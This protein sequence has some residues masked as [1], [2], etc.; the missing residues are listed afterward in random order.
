MMAADLGALSLLLALALGAYAGIGSVL[1]AWR[2]STEL[3][4]SARY[5]LY[6]LPVPL[7]VATLT[8]VA[9]FANHDF[10]L[11]Y[12]A[13]HSNLAM[14]PI[15]TWV[16]F[17]AGNEGSLLYIALAFSV[18]A[19]IAVGTAPRP[20]RSALPYTSAIL[21]AVMVFFLAVMATMAN[22]FA[23]LDAVPPDGRGI[24]P[25]L[26]HAGMFFHPPMLML[27]LIGV[28][29][30][31]A[32]A[33]GHLVSGPAED[34]WVD[35]GRRWGL[36]VWTVLTIGLLLGSWWAY[37]ILGWGGY[38]AWD[39]V[40][41]AGLLPWLPL[42][43]FVHSIMVQKRRGMFRLWNVAL[44][45][46]AFGMALYGMFMNRGGPVPSVHS[47]GQSTMGWVFLAF[48][49]AVVVGSFMAFF[50]RYNAFRSAAPLDSALSREAA[51]LVNNLLFLAIAFVVLWGVVFPLLS[52]AFKGETVTVARP[53]YD[54]VT[55]PLFLALLL[56]MGIA[57]LV[58]WRRASAKRLREALLWPVIV[59]IAVAA[60]AVIL[61]VR[62]PLPVVAFAF[63][64]AAATGILREW[65]KGTMA[66]HRRGHAYPSA[67]WSLLTANRPRYGGYV[68]HLGIV[69]LAVSVA[70]SSFYS[71]QR[72]VSLK[73]GGSATLG[74]YTLVYDGASVVQKADRTD[75]TASVRV[76]R[77]GRFLRTLEPG[78]SYYPEFNT[79]AAHAGIRSTP[80]E[81]LYIIANEF[82]GDGSAVFRLHVNPLVMWMWVSGGLFLA[83]MVVSLWPEAATVRAPS[84]VSS[85]VPAAASKRT[86]EVS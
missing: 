62:K 20:A 37:T 63:S 13:K 21:M 18:I 34:E 45:N 25:L 80:A 52:D 85:Q 22:P 66:Q 61:G 33:M 6:V 2:R 72:D 9:A 55:G 78:Y 59:S 42:T 74:D 40:E 67:F 39:P 58:P 76:Y 26:T 5:A 29:V 30:P 81:D 11:A 17:Y 65:F 19:A 1:G 43:A 31:F 54:V 47:F 73:P 12:V 24:N 75:Y 3:V 50:A 69:L 36:I 8:L 79:A 41:N 23:E 4:R 35:A 64:G 49:A 70:G 77:G 7:L 56:L 86:S 60:V 68:T 71:E 14:P 53:F 15:Y 27:G 84:P 10:S 16:A 51:F 48:L 83:G 82:S 38:W 32:F 44:I 57:P 46:I 28:A